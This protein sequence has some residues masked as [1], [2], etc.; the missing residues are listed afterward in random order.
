M[1]TIYLSRLVF[2]GGPYG[3]DL[4]DAYALHQRL[5]EVVPKTMMPS[6]SGE[7]TRRAYF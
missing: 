5:L 3:R 7:A 2:A 1:S 6:T 4:P